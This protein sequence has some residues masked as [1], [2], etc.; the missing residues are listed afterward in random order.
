MMMA[1]KRSLIAACYQRAGNP[2]GERV[3][4][5]PPSMPMPMPFEE[6]A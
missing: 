4:G 6:S 1:S 3:F 2:D 5:T